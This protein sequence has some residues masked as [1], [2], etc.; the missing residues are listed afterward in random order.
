[1][2][3]QR[4][5]KPFPHQ[6][7]FFSTLHYDGLFDFFSHQA[8]TPE[9]D[10]NFILV[11]GI[12]KPEPLLNHLRQ[13]AA[14]VHLLRYPDHHYFSAHNLDEI[15]K[16]H[17]QWAAPN[18]AIV[19][20]EKD[21]TRMALWHEELKSWNIPI[22]VQPVRVRFLKNELQFR[23]IVADYVESSRPLTED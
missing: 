19:V 2:D 22:Y 4:A 6:T 9:A 20:S 10:S 3:I 16:T 23:Q 1:M 13:Q 15:R 21:A 12:A 7:V 8:V 18:K 11:S 14:S 17:D 5:I